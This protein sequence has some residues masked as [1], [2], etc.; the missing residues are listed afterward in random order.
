MKKAGNLFI[1][2]A[3]ML[4]ASA[5]SKDSSDHTYG[6]YIKSVSE[7]GSIVQKFIYDESGK[8]VE[9]NSFYNFRKFIYDE[10]ER[11]VKI[12]S[13]WDR[14]LLSSSMPVQRT[15]F[16][17]SK[18]SPVDSYRLYEYDEE[19]RLSKIENYSDVVSGII[20]L[21]SV[22][23][24]EYE[25]KNIVRVNLLNP[26][27]NQITQFH[28]YTYD[29]YG[30]VINEKHYSNLFDRNEELIRE[31]FYKYDSYNNPFRI[32]YLT[33]SPGIYTNVNNIIETRSILHLDVLGIDKY[34]TEKRTFK[35]N[36]KGYPIKEITENGEFEYHY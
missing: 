31:T 33:G 23:I 2:I 14:S 18:N 30:N 1:F 9:E 12:E 19:G 13:A 3:L 22:S 11:L 21:R 6:D 28:V 8:I 7:N 25:W 32:F 10:N 35:Y 29:D 4:F 34:S 26:E 17:T 16:M 24:F 20:E 27:N 5:C 15:E 36:S